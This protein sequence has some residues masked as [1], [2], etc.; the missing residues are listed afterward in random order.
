MPEQYKKI[1]Q[2]GKCQESDEYMH[3]RAL[4][5]LKMSE[6]FFV[7]FSH[8]VCVWKGMVLIRQA[9]SVLTFSGHKRVTLE[10]TRKLS[11]NWTLMCPQSTQRHFTRANWKSKLTTQILIQSNAQRH[12]LLTTS[13]LHTCTFQKTGAFFLLLL[14]SCETKTKTK[15]GLRVRANCLPPC[16]YV[17]MFMKARGPPNFGYRSPAVPISLNNFT[18]SN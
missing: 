15:W 4:I 7:F 11:G 14:F 18:F 3:C 17:A 16:T 13:D 6:C 1:S 5:I 10:R 9:K 2:V 12:I 8:C